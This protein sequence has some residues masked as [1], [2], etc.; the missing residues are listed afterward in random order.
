MRRLGILVGAFVLALPM[1]LA[2]SSPAFASRGDGW[3]LLPAE[4]FDLSVCGTNMH[5]EF[6][7]NMEYT[8][9]AT[10]GG[11]E[12]LQVTGSLFVTIT[13]TNTGQSLTVSISGPGFSPLTTP[14]FNARGVNLIFL[15]PEDAATNGTPELF[16]SAGY[17]VFLFT[18]T[19]VILQ[20]LNGM[21]I[22]D[23]CAALT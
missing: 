14:Q 1:V 18:D 13:N 8:R 10:L 17:I 11:V 23:L 12:I 5:F 16:L 21:V 7:A 6:P 22:T 4:P 20:R 19:S 2:S 3:E 15:S 9:L